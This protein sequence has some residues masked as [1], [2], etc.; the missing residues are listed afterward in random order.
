MQNDLNQIIWEL[1]TN[2]HLCKTLIFL[3]SRIYIKTCT[4]EDAR[5]SNYSAKIVRFEGAA[6]LLLLFH[7][8]HFNAFW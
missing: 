5:F 1:Q 6:D 7:V 4:D 2:F 3:S 8:E